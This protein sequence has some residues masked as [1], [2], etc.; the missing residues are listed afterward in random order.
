VVHTHEL[1]FAGSVLTKRYV[2]WGRGEHRR[3]WTVL[4]LV[5]RCA[6]D[7]VPAPLSA[8]LDADPPVITMSRLPG[9]P[10]GGALSARQLAALAGAITRLWR[11][12]LEGDEQWTV[13]AGPWAD[14][15]A[16][17][18]RL[19][20]GPR[21]AAG[22]TRDAYD[23][24]VGW[25]NGPDPQLLRTRPAELILGHR[26]PNLANYLYDGDRV[27]IVDFEDAGMS[28]PANEI[29][30]LAEHMSAR[31]IEVSDLLAHFPAVDEQRLRAARRGWAMF[32]LRL[33][34]PGG[35]AARRNP[36]GTAE[37]QAARL[38]DLLA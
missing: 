31:D 4:R 27:R 36:P 38:L 7:L 23:A 20:D 3:E 10:L 35:P 18:R 1:T 32:W 26:D 30:I 6:P 24:A 15:L 11:V 22:L 13:M 12:P 29:A 33:L 5:H 8:R 14:D 9:E 34:L 17:A 21:P 16:F 37:R 25:W 2:S 28:D 19:T